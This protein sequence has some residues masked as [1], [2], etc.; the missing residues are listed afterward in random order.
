M[1]VFMKKITSFLVCVSTSFF[2]FA[3]DSS[4]YLRSAPSVSKEMLDSNYWISKTVE[5][6]SVI[7]NIDEIQK[8]N[9]DYE[10]LNATNEKSYSYYSASSKNNKISKDNLIELLDF[11]FDKKYYKEGSEISDSYK[12]KLLEYRNIENIKASNEVSYAFILRRGGLRV[13]PTEDILTLEENRSFYDE[14]QNTSVLM[15]EPVVVLHQTKDASWYYVMTSY[16]CGWVSVTN[17]AFCHSYDEWNKYKNPEDFLVVGEN[18]FNLDY[19]WVN[20]RISNVEVSMGTK[21]QL[22]P[23]SEYEKSDEGREAFDNYIVRIPDRSQGGFLMFHNA[24]IPLGRKV[25]V[26]Y[27]PYTRRN[28]LNMAFSAL[29]ERLGFAGVYGA[30]DASQFVMELYRAF[31]FYLPRTTG[32]LISMN[33]P[34]IDVE[35][36]STEHKK[37]ILQYVPKGSLLL[38]PGHVMIYLGEINGKFYVISASGENI[39]SSSEKITQTQGVSVYDLETKRKSGQTC[40]EAITKVKIMY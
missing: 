14:M 25:Y 34:T 12:E 28:L 37:S 38:I 16:C 18:K 13:L 9:K 27:V 35:K 15:N 3:T 11:K 22:V 2:L 30:R 6:D 5:P 39:Y 17:I 40:L 1:R 21:L 33:T 7:L 10:L 24:Y 32:E 36:M 31:G 29:G 23:I 8:L 4:K 19:N 20:D 26:G